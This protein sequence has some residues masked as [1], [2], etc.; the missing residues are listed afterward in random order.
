MTH[1]FLEFTKALELEA[2]RRERVRVYRRRRRWI[3]TLRKLRLVDGELSIFDDVPR[4]PQA[5]R[6]RGSR[7]NPA[8]RELGFQDVVQ[9]MDQ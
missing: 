9:G 6:E 4:P 1:R 8:T 2:R 5:V 7:Y 3:A